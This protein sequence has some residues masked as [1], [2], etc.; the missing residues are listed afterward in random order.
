[1]AASSLSV[2]VRVVVTLF[3]AV[4]LFPIYSSYCYDRVF[5]PVN[6]ACPLGAR[7]RRSTPGYGSL[8]QPLK[9]HRE[10]EEA[11]KKTR[12]LSRLELLARPVVLHIPGP[13]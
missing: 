11:S 13:D 3:C 12:F 8:F 10:S 5:L 7:N 2:C 1:M 6:P 9:S 4:K